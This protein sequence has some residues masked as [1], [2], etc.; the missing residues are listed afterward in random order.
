M[1]DILDTTRVAKVIKK[2]RFSVTHAQRYFRE[3]LEMEKVQ[4]T[5]LTKQWNRVEHELES[6]YYVELEHRRQKQVILSK[7]LY[8]EGARL[9]KVNFISN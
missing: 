8:Y 5:V 9:N 7:S 4:L 1:L 3:M 6:A 2:F